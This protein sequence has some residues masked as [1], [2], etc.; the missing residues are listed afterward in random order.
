MS[1]RVEFHKDVLIEPAWLFVA[2]SNSES[3]SWKFVLERFA[4]VVFRKRTLSNSKAQ[5]QG[6][7]PRIEV[8]L[9]GL[10]LASEL[11]LSFKEIKQALL[12]TWK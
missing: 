3:S 1:I 9:K 2:K 11:R 8:N 6:T 10:L 12:A 4:A 5:P 7:D